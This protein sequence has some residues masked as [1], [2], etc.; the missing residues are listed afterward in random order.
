MGRITDLLNSI[1][2]TKEDTEELYSIFRSVKDNNLPIIRFILYPGAG[3]I[4]QRVNEKGRD[5]NMISDLSYPP[6]YCIRGYERANLPYQPMFYACSFPVNYDE[7]NIPP[8]RVIALQET[9]SFFKD[10]SSSGIE[11]CTVSRW[12]V[13]KDLELVAMPFLADYKMPYSLIQQIK[14]GWNNMLQTNDVNEDGRELVEYMANEIG[15]EFQRNVDYFKIANFVNYLL[16]VSEKTKNV[17]GVIYP[18]VP[19]GGSGFNIALRPS[20]I[21]EKVQFVGASLC[22]LLKKGET[23]YLCVM[24]TTESVS[25]GIITYKDIVMEDDDKKVYQAYADGLSFIN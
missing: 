12:V 23:S 4:R 5:F 21:G 3:L 11:R 9:S 24:N 7:E 14:D 20:V 6:A 10:K 2:V 18:S 13:T 22:N 16:N 8:P 15:K 1:D 19:A 25:D 17:D